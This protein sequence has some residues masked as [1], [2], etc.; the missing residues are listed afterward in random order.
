MLFATR[1]GQGEMLIALNEGHLNPVH[2]HTHTPHM[3]T[4]TGVHTCAS[5]KVQCTSS[6]QAN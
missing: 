5:F 4:H 3:H 1:Y 2:T 6:L